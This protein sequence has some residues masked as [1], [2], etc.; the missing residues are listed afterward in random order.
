MPVFIIPNPWNMNL[1][2]NGRTLDRVLQPYT[3]KVQLFCMCRNKYFFG[4][5]KEISVPFS[6]DTY[7]ITIDSLSSGIH[8]YIQKINK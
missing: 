7:A 1:Q 5:Y 4:A 8:T 3:L 2:L 6:E